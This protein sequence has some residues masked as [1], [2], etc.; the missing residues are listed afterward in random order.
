MTQL[1][2]YYI[3]VFKRVREREEQELHVTAEIKCPF[4]NLS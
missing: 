2:Q 3:S 4:Q 1:K